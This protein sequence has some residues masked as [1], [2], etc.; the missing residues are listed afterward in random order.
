MRTILLGTDGSPSAARATSAAIEL[1]AKTGWPLRIVT[2]WTFSAFDPG[3]A[4]M[5]VGDAVNSVREQAQAALDEAVAEAEAAGLEVTAELRFGPAAE[6]LCAA[7]AEAWN[8]LVVVGSHGRRGV[9]RALLG[10]VSAR[11]LHHSPWPVLVA[12][13]TADETERG[14]ADALTTKGA[15]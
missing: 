9:S 15:T 13:Q 1:A 11:L 4:P 5:P 7:A 14:L 8:P 2:A 12:R 10:S 3:L 6:E